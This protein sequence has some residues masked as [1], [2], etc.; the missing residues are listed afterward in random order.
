MGE[1][2]GGRREG[3]KT[4]EREIERERGEVGEKKVRG[5]GSGIKIE[6]ER[7]SERRKVRESERDRGRNK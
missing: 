4:C 2:G 5:R 1:G 6:R 3:E 7:G